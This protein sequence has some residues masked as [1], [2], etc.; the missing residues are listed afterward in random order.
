M[1]AEGPTLPSPLLRDVALCKAMAPG[2]HGQVGSQPP[3]SLGSLLVRAEEK[4][5]LC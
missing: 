2:L 1:G 4:L 5:A 3:L